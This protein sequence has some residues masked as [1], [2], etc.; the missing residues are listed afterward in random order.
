[1]ET[2]EMM[3]VK[4]AELH[5]NP[6]QPQSRLEVTEA[7]SR[8]FGLSILGKGLLQ[9]PVCRVVDKGKG[10]SEYQMV[11]G[12]L[13]R[14]GFL[15]LVANGH[16]EYT[17][18]PVMLRVFTDQQMADMI[19]VANKERHDLTPIDLAWY[20]KKYLAEF[21]GITQAKFAKALNVSQGEIANTIRLLELPEEVQQ[22]IISHEITESHGRTLLQLKEAGLILDYAKDACFHQW[23]VAELAAVIKTYLDSQQPRMP[24]APSAVI[25]EAPIEVITEAVPEAAE[26]KATSGQKA[27]TKNKPVAPA[28]SPQTKATP[29][30]AASPAPVAVNWGRKLVI[31]EKKDHVLISVMKAGGMPV[32]KKVEGT[33]VQAMGVAT[34]WVEDLAAEWAKEEK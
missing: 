20:Y 13:R 7:V 9:I 34:G 17:R 25:T 6:Y 5:P 31:E 14:S 18:M 30:P 10:T 26:T 3:R 11:D 32:F 19:Y 27:A 33:L 28:E 4:L 21:K 22:M 2:G 15:W 24:V 12:W 23:S 1:M 29:S 16:P 8:E